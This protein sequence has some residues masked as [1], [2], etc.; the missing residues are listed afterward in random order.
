[1]RN[2]SLRHQSLVGPVAGYGPNCGSHADVGYDERCGGVECRPCCRL[3]VHA[4]GQTMIKLGI[5][6]FLGFI[7]YNLG[8]GCWYMLTERSDST[9]AVK[10]LS[11]R[12]G[13]SILLIGLIGL[14]IATGVVKPHGILN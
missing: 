4:T 8:M 7:V 6:L 3:G 11:W 9:R 2:P 5:I 12:I 14:G 1:M 13:L 10:A